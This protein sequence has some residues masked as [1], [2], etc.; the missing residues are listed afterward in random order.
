MRTRFRSLDWRGS[1][2]ENAFDDLPARENK[3]RETRREGYRETIEGVDQRVVVN[4]VKM[5]S[6]RFLMGLDQHV[7][8]RVY[9]GRL[10]IV[11][12]NVL[13]RRQAKCK[14]QGTAGLQ[15]DGD[16]RASR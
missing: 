7:K 13:K 14:Q 10:T 3:R 12:M 11:G 6:G 5:N 1:D 15:N 8:V 4:V 16:A 2:N 9:D